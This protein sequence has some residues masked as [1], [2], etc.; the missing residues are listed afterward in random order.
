MFRD[1]SG[2]LANVPSVEVLQQALRMGICGTVGRCGQGDAAA[3]S[4]IGQI[5]EAVRGRLAEAHLSGQEE[6]GRKYILRE[7]ARTGGPPTSAAIAAALK[8]PSEEAAEKIVEKLNQS[9]IL[10]CEGK[11]IVSAYPFSARQTRHKV[12]FS[13]GR[14]VH[15]LC[16]TDALGM[17][18]MLGED[19]TVRSRCPGCE[20]EMTI[21]VKGDSIASAVPDGIVEFISK[22]EHC[23]CTARTFCP[24]MNFFCSREHLEAWRER[25][26]ANGAGEMYELR[27]VLEHGKRIFGDFLK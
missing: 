18:F 3:K 21:G 1:E 4:L 16:A 7:F 20:Q 15:A 2:G 5:T 6:D 8:L 9:D 14:E 26:A 17:H 12:V 25:N 11:T 27:E 24:F 19:I 13:D 22:Q 23:G 10:T